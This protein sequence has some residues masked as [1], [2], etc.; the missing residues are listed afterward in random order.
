MSYG[1]HWNIEGKGHNDSD[2][3][4]NKNSRKRPRTEAQIHA[5]GKARER[6]SEVRREKAFIRKREK[7]IEIAKKNE[8]NDQRK[9]ALN[10]LYNQYFEKNDEE[11]KEVSDDDDLGTTNNLD[12]EPICTKNEGTT[13]DNLYCVQWVNIVDGKTVPASYYKIGRG[14]DG[15]EMQ[16]HAQNPVKFPIVNVWTRLGVLE[17]LIHNE[18]NE[19]RMNLGGGIEWFNLSHVDDVSSFIENMFSTL[20]R[21]F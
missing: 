5:L 12:I 2:N 20:T 16:V 1:S 4:V 10:E 17:T 15:R 18:L 14:K 21:R 13:P 11:T 9:Q 3:D 8:M 6:A 7:A 19:Y